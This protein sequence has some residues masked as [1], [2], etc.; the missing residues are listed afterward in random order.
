[1]NEHTLG[2]LYPR[3]AH[4]SR[5]SRACGRGDGREGGR[6]EGAQCLSA[7]FRI[8]L[9][10][11]ASLFSAPAHAARVS[12]PSEKKSNRRFAVRVLYG[13][14]KLLQYELCTGP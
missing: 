9:H 4:T 13:G 1:M 5:Y 2:L 6:W 3:G 11:S 14:L 12:V 10:P 8:L 7:S